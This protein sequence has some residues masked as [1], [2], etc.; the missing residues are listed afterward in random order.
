MH[1][2]DGRRRQPRAVLFD[3]TGTLIALREPVGETYARFAGE[4]GVRLSAWRLGDAFARVWRGAP[5]MVF[6]GTTP[7][8]AAARERHAWREIVRR[9]FLA[10]E[11]T[12]RIEELGDT[13]D[14]LFAH[15]GRG[16]AWRVREG[17]GLALSALREAGVATAVVSNFD[18]RLRGILADLGLAA[19]LDLVWLPADAGAAK[20]D[21]AIYASALH[22]LGV[23]AER[24]LF[25]G[26]DAERDLA[27]AEAAGLLAVDAKS[28]ATLADVPA[29]LERAFPEEPIR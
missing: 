28:L 12:A 26:D 8:E 13:F 20:P 27:G 11:A 6:P 9:T 4:R 7:E 23:A 1:S 10:A 16:A 24:A 15:Y 18:Q 21:P 22:A 3:A 14:A 19:R 25:V 2:A 17:A 5:P 29:L